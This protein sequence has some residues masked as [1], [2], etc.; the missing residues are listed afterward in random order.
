MPL[1][2]KGDTIV[3]ERLWQLPPGPDGGRPHRSQMNELYKLLKVVDGGIKY[4]ED[5]PCILTEFIDGE[6]Y[7][8]TDY[9]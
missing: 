2:Y 3:V 4:P 1:E 9:L 6:F 5:M 8:K 7:I